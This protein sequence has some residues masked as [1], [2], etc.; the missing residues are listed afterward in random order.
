MLMIGIR[1]LAIVFILVVILLGGV[2][3]RNRGSPNQHEAKY[4][5]LASV[6]VSREVIC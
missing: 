4:R 2:L 6:N 1:P 3:K 5:S